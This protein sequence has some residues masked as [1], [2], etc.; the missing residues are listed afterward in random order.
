MNLPIKIAGTGLYAPGEPIDNAE[1]KRLTALEF[2]SDKIEQKI[3]IYRRHIARLR[4]ID[5]SA[6]DFATKA[7][8]AALADAGISADQVGL[9]IVGTDTPEYISPA[10]A[11]VVQGR[12]QGAETWAQSFDISASCA[13]FTMAFDAAARI[14]ATQ[15]EIKYALVTGVY[16]M[17]AFIHNDDKFSFPIFADGAAAFV[18]AAN[19]NSGRSEY[20]G[21]QMLTDGTQWDYIGIYAG[22]A[23]N[24][25]SQKMLDEKTHGLL[26]LKPLP[27]DRNVRLWPMV[28]EKIL[29]KYGTKPEKIDHYIFTQINRS[30]IVKVMDAIGQP[31]EKAHFIMDNYGYTGSACVPMT[32]HEGVKSGQIHRGDKALFIASGSGLAVGSNLF[33]Y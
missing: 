12:I 3:G 7:A 25:L 20:I 1:L 23:K 28:I 11:I 32:F 31:Q 14:M 5:E 33:I 13:S 16:N 4:G 29:Q 2:D 24:P 30:V 17:P 19:E 22:G 8:L 6:A 18:L 9:F 26:S 10:T 21:S 27:G 15:S